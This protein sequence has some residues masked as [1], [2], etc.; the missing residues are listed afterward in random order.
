MSL[1]LTLLGEPQ[2]GLPSLVGFSLHWDVGMV[3]LEGN[4]RR[5]LASGFGARPRAALSGIRD[6]APY[7]I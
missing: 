6:T 1:E 2:N 4:F 3:R 7:L 5:V